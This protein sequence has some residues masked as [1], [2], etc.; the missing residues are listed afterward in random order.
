ME[1]WASLGRKEGRTNIRISAE[2]RIEMGNFWL[3]G[4]DLTNS[5]KNPYSPYPHPKKR[6]EIDA[7]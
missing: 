5:D 4:R 3:E 6:K 2:H 1:S 7:P